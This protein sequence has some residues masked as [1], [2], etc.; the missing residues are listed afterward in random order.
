MY[1]GMCMGI[2]D[3]AETS[4]MALCLYLLYYSI[5]VPTTVIEHRNSLL[6]TTVTMRHGPFPLLNNRQ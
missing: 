2:L 1:L 3:I 5:T 6:T 4:Y